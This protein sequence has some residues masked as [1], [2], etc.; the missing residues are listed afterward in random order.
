[1]Q[2]SDL[3][4]LVYFDFNFWRVDVCKLTL[5]IGKIPFENK[6]VSK[7]YFIINK[8]SDE[9][10][11]GQVPLLHVNEKI[12]A[13]TSAMIRYCGKITGLYPSD[14]FECALVD[15]TIDFANDVTNLIIPSIREQDL[16]RKKI[17]RE[18]LNNKILP[19]WLSYLERF[20]KNNNCS[21]FFITNKLTIADII[22]WRILLWMTSGKLEHISIDLKLKY[23]LLS[24]YY[25][26]ISNFTRLTSL[27]D[28]SQ[29]VS[30]QINH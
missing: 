21:N 9:F 16:K 25:F 3:I 12:I 1:M 13:Q 2:K 15:Q 27:K 8:E 11:F 6:I 10:P 18:E 4:K 17:K 28:F 20:L 19:K 7:R 23:P 26:F 24:N 5:A 22:V 30:N 14:I 29:I